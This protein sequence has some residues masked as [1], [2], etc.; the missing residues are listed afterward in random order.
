M[1]LLLIRLIADNGSRRRSDS[2]TDDR[3]ATGMTGRAADN[4]SGACA[5]PTANECAFLRLR[6]T[7]RQRRCHN[8]QYCQGQS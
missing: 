6:L 1:S 7:T 8:S 5:Q 2:A 3:T 4:G